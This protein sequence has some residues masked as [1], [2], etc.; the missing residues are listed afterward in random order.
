MASGFS[1]GIEGYS[2]ATV[3]TL[4]VFLS[5]A[6]ASA[7]E[8][9]L[10]IWATFKRHSGLYFWA[11]LGSTWGVFP[12]CAG[13]IVKYFCPASVGFLAGVL[14]L[15]GWIFM[16]SGQSVVLWSRLHLVMTSRFR[17]TMVKWIIIINGC[18]MHGAT[19]P[20]VIASFSSN[21]DAWS[22]PYSIMEKIEVTVFFIQ[23]VGISG[24]YIYETSRLMKVMSAIDKPSS[25]RNCL[26]KQLIIVNSVIILL[27]STILAL[28]YAD[29]YQIQTAYKAFVYS[30]KLK[31]EFTILN[32]LVDFT[33]RKGGGN[34][35]EYRTTANGHS[36]VG[37]LQPA[38]SLPTGP[39]CDNVELHPMGDVTS[40]AYATG[41]TPS[42]PISH[43]GIIMTKEITIHETEG[44][45]DFDFH[46]QTRHAIEDSYSISHH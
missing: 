1:S 38:T 39:F 26:M 21:A 3:I 36:G 13:F 17:L 45:D 20:M 37:G 41:T 24:L 7:L 19:C 46:G 35:T 28:E 14:I 2:L 40:R 33:V 18:L 32:S 6:I 4:C 42:R 12:Y 44:Q 34:P 29:H 30:T 25:K 23:E 43:D 27:D 31:L 5:I 10:I 22:L 15:I 16:V 11:F 9:T 8:L